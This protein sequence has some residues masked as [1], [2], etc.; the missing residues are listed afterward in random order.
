LGKKIDRVTANFVNDPEPCE[1]GC[2]GLLMEFNIRNGT[3]GINPVQDVLAILKRY[4]P[5]TYCKA[6]S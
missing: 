2:S 1:I 4:C 3:S 6:L 5:A